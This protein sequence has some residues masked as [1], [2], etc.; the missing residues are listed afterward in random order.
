MQKQSEG[1]KGKPSDQ[2][3]GIHPGRQ[4][5]PER[6]QAGDRERGADLGELMAKVSYKHTPETCLEKLNADR[7]FA[8]TAKEFE[9]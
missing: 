5:R 9:R 6:Q 2:A 8:Q 4:S 3:K 1:H 7:S